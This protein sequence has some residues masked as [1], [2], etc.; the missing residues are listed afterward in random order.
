MKFFESRHHK[1]EIVTLTLCAVIIGAIF[2]PYPGANAVQVELQNKDIQAGGNTAVDLKVVAQNPAAITF[3]NGQNSETLPFGEI[4]V[5]LDSGTV[6]EKMVRFNFTGSTLSDNTGGIITGLTF[7]GITHGTSVGTFGNGYYYGYGAGFFSGTFQNNTI[8]NGTTV[9]GISSQPYGEDTAGS[10][11]IHFDP[12]LLPTGTHV[13]RVDVLAKSTDTNFF[14]SGDI[15]FTNSPSIPASITLDPTSGAVGTTVTV[16]GLHFLPLHPVVTKF[17]GHPATKPSA[18]KTDSNGVFTVSFMVPS[19][20]NGSHIVTISDGTNS[21][22][23][24]FTVTTP[25]V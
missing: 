6:N 12:S 11:Q 4:R 2:T 14:S 13:I 22:S 3:P 19:S 10:Y 17:D 8:G 25:W 23:A 16:T 15:S 24:T 5:T 20:K 18:I 1:R 7:N 21:A 9:T